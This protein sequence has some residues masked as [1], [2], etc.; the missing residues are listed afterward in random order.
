MFLMFLFY[1]NI[2]VYMKFAQNP[3]ICCQDIKQKLN[4]DVC[5]CVVVLRPSQPNGFMSSTVSLPNHT[6]TG[7]T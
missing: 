1:E 7:Q 6:F 2:N 4:S 5:V 3:S